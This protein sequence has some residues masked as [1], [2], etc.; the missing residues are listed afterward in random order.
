MAECM[1]TKDEDPD[2][3]HR[4]QWCILRLERRERARLAPGRLFVVDDSLPRR[5]A[6]REPDRHLK[7][8]FVVSKGAER[9]PDRLLKRYVAIGYGCWNG[10]CGQRYRAKHKPR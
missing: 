8:L 7:R 9:E 5:G 2:R 1:E 4:I 3:V 6:E 10:M